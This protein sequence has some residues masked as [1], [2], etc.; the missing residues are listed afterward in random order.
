MAVRTAVIPAAGLGTRFLPATKAQPKG[1][2]PVV[3]T[4]AIQLVV[5]EAVAAGLDDVVVVIGPGQDA[6]KEHF[7]PNPEL[8]AELEARGKTEALAA[9]R[10][11][12]IPGLR[13]ALQQEARGLGHA[14][15][16]AEELVGDR[17]F[18]VLLGDDLIAPSVKL[19]ERMIAG[20]ERTGGAVI[21]AMDVG[22]REISMYGCIEPGDEDGD[23]VRIVSLVEKPPAD[24]APSSLAVMGRYVFGP[25]VFDALRRTPPGAGN[26]IQLTDAIALLIS[27]EKV[28]ALPF[29]GGRYDVGNPLDAMKAQVAIAASRDDIGPAFREWLHDFVEEAGT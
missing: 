21:A 25:S 24:E 28:S 11:A 14:V 2:L 20:F 9:V 10:R 23:L 29:E 3:D 27:E 8:E 26:E 5:E 22:P 6:L 16:Q 4:P 13:S 7:A 19:L 12:T 18:A 15:A 1:L 17:P